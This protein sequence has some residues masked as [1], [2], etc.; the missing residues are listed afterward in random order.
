[1]RHY[2]TDSNHNFN[3]R[4]VNSENN[5]Q[6]FP[7]RVLFSL[8]PRRGERGFTGSEWKQKINDST[9]GGTGPVGMG[10][11]GVSGGSFS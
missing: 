5:G 4:V 7:L 2:V 6:R 8:S 9:D 11:G 1:M 3:E 10:R